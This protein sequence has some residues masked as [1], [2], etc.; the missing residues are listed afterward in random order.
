MFSP[1]HRAAPDG[2]ATIAEACA[3]VVSP[4]ATA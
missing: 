3:D 1:T 2:D 4:E